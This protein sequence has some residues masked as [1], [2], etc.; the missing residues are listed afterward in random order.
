MSDKRILHPVAGSQSGEP[1]NHP[2]YMFWCPGCKCGHGIWATRPNRGGAQWQ[3][4][5]NLERPTVSPSLL[6][7]CPE[8]HPPV[9]HENLEEWR[10]NP[11]PQTQVTKV[12]HLFIVDGQLQF[13][14]DCTHELAGKTV[15][16]EAF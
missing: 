10:K 7:T 16:M 12:C 4:N 13:L 8:W 9:T 3:F 5:G 6:I 14:S 1:S 2:D 15:P 11:W